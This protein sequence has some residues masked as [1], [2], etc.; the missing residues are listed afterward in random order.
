MTLTQ[1]AFLTKRIII[2]AV[3]ALVST[4]LI[5]I[6][7]K[8]WYAYYLSHLPPVEEKPDLKFGPLPA[9]DFPKTSASS[10]NFSY[11]LDTITGGLPKLGEQGFEKIIK[12]YF[13]TQSFA[14][15]LAPERS[16][17]LAEKFNFLSQPNILSETK[18][19]FRDSSKNLTINL[20][21]G[22]F[23][24]SSEATL[25]ARVLDD[26]NK[27]VND[28]KQ[29]LSSL[30]ILKDDLN[31][32]RTKVVLLK[33]EGNNLLSTN[34]R[35]EAQAAQISLWPAPIDKKSIFTADYNKSLVNGLVAGSADKIDNFIS[36]NFT[37]Y[38]ID[39]SVFATYP[40]KS[41][42]SAFEDLKNG[43]GIVVIEPN[44]PQVSISSV[45]PGYF[46]P[47]NYNPYLLPIYI[48]EGPNFVA[49]VPAIS[50]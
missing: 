7:Y 19:Q 21:N 13:I 5:F 40:T 6:G 3:L 50:P 23:T 14:S 11:S 20:D 26:D 45:Y 35:S 17:S 2:I 44:K 4:T 12:V 31:T 25:S 37:Y 27:L 22:N 32:G 46:L 9:P 38:Q 1:I 18:Y 24:F 10:S 28:F 34:L 15:L 29:T 41:P 42:D 43:K 33:I 8:L 30:G 16:Q 49:Y 47:E 39:L 36:L 48:F